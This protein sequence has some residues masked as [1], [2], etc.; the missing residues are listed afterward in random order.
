MYFN[1]GQAL[2]QWLRELGA[3]DN[4]PSRLIAGIDHRR[5]ESVDGQLGGR[6]ETARK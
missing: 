1:A 2:A 5:L 6:E 3:V 4:N